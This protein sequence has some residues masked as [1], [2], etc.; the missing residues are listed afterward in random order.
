MKDTGRTK[1]IESN[2]NNQIF[3]SYSAPFKLYKPL[4]PVLWHPK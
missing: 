2:I 3:L 1:P 4:E